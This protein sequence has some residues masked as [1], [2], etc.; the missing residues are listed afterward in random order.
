MSTTTILVGEGFVGTGAHVAHVNVVLGQRDGPVGTAW[1]TAL[2]TPRPGHVAFVCVARPGVPVEPPTLFVNKAT[3][4]GPVHEQLTWGA[5]QAGVAGG[6]ADHIRAAGWAL[7]RAATN[8][9]I[10]SVW[11][12]P[13]ASDPEAIYANNR[14]ATALALAATTPTQASWAAFISAAADPWNPY[15][16]PR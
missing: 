2:A 11:V 4:A 6:V 12:D 10:A 13:T 9:L 8:L 16:R 7:A 15:F 5:A 3:L 1:A 14:A